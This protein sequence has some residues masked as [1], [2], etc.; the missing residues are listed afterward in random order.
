M[1]LEVYIFQNPGPESS[2]GSRDLFLYGSRQREDSAKV[3][4]MGYI[5][6]E[7]TTSD[8]RMEWG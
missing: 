4:E 1:G 3:G 8:G 7:N 2:D 5:F 6:E